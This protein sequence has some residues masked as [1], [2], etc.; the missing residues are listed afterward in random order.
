MR[1]CTADPT[2]DCTEAAVSL[3]KRRTGI[4]GSASEETFSSAVA[5]VSL[6]EELHDGFP[7]GPEVLISDA[8]P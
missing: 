7:G 6:C 3:G 8:K 1:G 4:F 2:P 5:T